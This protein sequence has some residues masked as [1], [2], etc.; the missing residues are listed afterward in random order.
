[1]I[2]VSANRAELEEIP[3]QGPH[4]QHNPLDESQLSVVDAANEVQ[5]VESIALMQA[6]K[7]SQFI[8]PRARRPLCFSDLRK[9]RGQFR[10]W[11]LRLLLCR[12]YTKRKCQTTCRTCGIKQIGLPVAL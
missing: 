2:G 1:M 12:Q 8:L 10:S 3:L 5:T 6:L 4:A 11:T 7:T 9:S